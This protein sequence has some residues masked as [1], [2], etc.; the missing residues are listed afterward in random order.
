[1]MKELAGL[2]MMRM[3]Q[4][5]SSTPHIRAIDGVYPFDPAF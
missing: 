4:L 3:K 1:M 5:K 2:E